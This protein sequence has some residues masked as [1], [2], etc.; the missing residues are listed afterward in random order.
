VTH[1]S[2]PKRLSDQSYLSTGTTSSLFSNS[3]LLPTMYSTTN[4]TATPNT[5]E[6]VDPRLT[7]PI[8]ADQGEDLPPLSAERIRAEASQV[9]ANNTMSMG[10]KFRRRSTGS[11]SGLGIGF[12]KRY[13]GR[14]RA[15]SGSGT[16]LRMNDSAKGDVEHSGGEEK[17]REVKT[18]YTE[19][20]RS[21][22][23]G[24]GAENG[25]GGTGGSIRIPSFD[26]HSQYQPAKIDND[27][28]LTRTETIREEATSSLRSVVQPDTP[29][30]S[31]SSDPTRSPTPALTSTSIPTRT[32]SPRLVHQ[33]SSSI[34]LAPTPTEID[35][36][37]NT[38]P[39]T[40]THATTEASAVR[41]NGLSA[42]LVQGGKVVPPI[43]EKQAR[44]SGTFGPMKFVPPALEASLVQ[45]SLGVDDAD[46][47]EKEK[48]VEAPEKGDVAH[49]TP[50]VND[51][52]AFVPE[53]E[54]NEKS[55]T[56]T[57]RTL[58]QH[59]H[60]HP[61]PSLI[62]AATFRDHLGPALPISN[63]KPVIS[64]ILTTRTRGTYIPRNNT[65]GNLSAE[66][67][68]STGTGIGNG[69]GQRAKE[70]KSPNSQAKELGWARVPRGRSSLGGPGMMGRRT[71]SMPNVPTIQES[72]TQPGS[73]QAEQANGLRAE[74][75]QGDVW[76]KRDRHEV[77][78]MIKAELTYEVEDPVDPE[79]NEEAEQQIAPV[80]KDPLLTSVEA[81]EQASVPPR[82]Q[83]AWDEWRRPDKMDKEVEQQ[84]KSNVGEGSRRRTMSMDK[85]LPRLPIESI[86]Q[87]LAGAEADVT[88]KG[89][90]NTTTGWS[91][92]TSKGGPFWGHRRRATGTQSVNGDRPGS[93]QN[94]FAFPSGRPAARA[95]SHLLSRQAEYPPIQQ[96]LMPTVRPG[97][98][99]PVPESS[100]PLLLASALLSQQASQIL[101]EL[102]SIPNAAPGPT[103][104]DGD[105]QVDHLDAF[106]K[107]MRNLA[108][109]GNEVGRGLMDCVIG[110]HAGRT[111]QDDAG[112]ALKRARFDLSGINQES[113]E[114][115][116][117]RISLP[118][119]THSTIPVPSVYE[120][121]RPMTPQYEYGRYD[122][123]GREDIWQ[124]QAMLDQAQETI[125]GLQANLNMLRPDLGDNGCFGGE[126][127]R[128]ERRRTFWGGR[129]RR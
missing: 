76:R 75:V 43:L 53:E 6:S 39:I 12:L 104:A 19:S 69:I 21:E 37:T 85:D 105:D 4:T 79:R 111:D 73:G 20:H 89:G 118:T 74:Q 32:P 124:M 62:P 66:N 29:P 114:R 10:K 44:I 126:Q 88:S 121:G 28:T 27:R 54:I 33:R 84:P 34:F 100:M 101:I 60:Q 2:Q 90:W 80:S 40:T 25:E 65:D 46:V 23:A 81:H 93:P 128:M 5:S 26:H 11:G 106:K 18:I 122:E 9:A 49:A 87:G 78:R 86:R 92:D 41:L 96:T 83:T 63:E 13:M 103:G 95:H 51:T 61:F 119:S 127:Q 110:S 55:Q 91:K 24:L 72:E 58:G 7:K 115:R 77:V 113:S 52:L 3:S 108:T 82:P 98:P 56:E 31:L 117:R 59:Q 94:R 102:S 99:M 30:S 97:T 125:R 1:R 64:G 129:R 47:E 14:L 109:E 123:G 107:K 120:A 8:T 48:S 70:E 35:T 68:T 38:Q 22:K 67:G 36:N 42:A 45:P 15:G 116:S 57:I 50:Q 71:L 16:G 112:D 17:Y